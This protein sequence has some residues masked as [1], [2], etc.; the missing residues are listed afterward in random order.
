MPRP[1]GTTIQKKK[2]NVSTSCVWIHLSSLFRTQLTI[3]WCPHSGTT[4]QNKTSGSSMCKGENEQTHRLLMPSGPSPVPKPSEPKY[5][6]SYHHT[7]SGTWHART[8]SLLSTQPNTNKMVS[9]YQSF[10]S[11]QAPLHAPVLEILTSWVCPAHLHSIQ[12]RSVQI[13]HNTAEAQAC[14]HSQ[15]VG[16]SIVEQD[17]SKCQ[18]H[19]CMNISSSFTTHTYDLFMH[20]TVEQSEPKCQSHHQAIT[21]GKWHAHTH[22]LWIPSTGNKI[23]VWRSS[24]TSYHN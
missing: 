2:Q 22:D 5:Q 14:T 18:S 12:K 7:P 10:I 23:S 1:V 3:C 17:K 19:H 15:P 13:Q 16:P 24:I 21:C 8:H 11:H 4:N 6:L 9:A 20:S